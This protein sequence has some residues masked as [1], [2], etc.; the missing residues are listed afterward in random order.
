[1]TDH[2]VG[3]GTA[4]RSAILG[5]RSVTSALRSSIRLDRVC[6]TEPEQYPRA[7]PE[8]VRGSALDGHL[9]APSLILSCEGKRSTNGTPQQESTRGTPRERVRVTGG[10]I[11]PKPGIPEM[12]RKDVRRVL[13]RNLTALME[14][15][16]YDPKHS[17]PAA[18][19]HRH[20]VRAVLSRPVSAVWVDPARALKMKQRTQRAL[21]RLSER[22]ARQVRKAAGH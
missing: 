20:Q 17:G 3:R 6:R 1:M 19:Y 4:K 21:Q 12:R 18:P 13:T 16:M 10:C 22:R 14:A 7:R 2:R 15:T 8:N 11:L 5:R 9:R